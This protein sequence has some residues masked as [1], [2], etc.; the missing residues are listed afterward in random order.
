MLRG[1][2][3]DTLCTLDCGHDCLHLSDIYLIISISYHTCPVA[4]REE[5]RFKCDRSASSATPKHD[6]LPLWYHMNSGCIYFLFCSLPL[7]RRR[8][9]GSNPYS[10]IWC[11]YTDDGDELSRYTPYRVRQWKHDSM[12]ACRNVH[13]PTGKGGRGWWWSW[14]AGIAKKWR[15][16]GRVG[17]GWDCVLA[18]WDDSG[19]LG[20]QE[21]GTGSSME[22]VLVFWK[23]KWK[24]IVCLV[25]PSFCPFPLS[26]FPFP[27]SAA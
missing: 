5:A 4:V 1:S 3:Y 6:A 18:D 23:M 15:G 9:S 25:S 26:L 20:W 14:L 2:R 16:G 17:R 11:F 27:F 10:Y 19:S 13:F 21:T 24:F 8:N 22:G 7:W 12:T